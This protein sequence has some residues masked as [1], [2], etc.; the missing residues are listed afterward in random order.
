MCWHATK[1]VAASVTAQYRDALHI[2]ILQ[3]TGFNLQNG[4]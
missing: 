4:G 1:S 3:L 2:D